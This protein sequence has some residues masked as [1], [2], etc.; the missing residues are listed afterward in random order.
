M[1]GETEEK[2]SGWTVDT[3]RVDFLARLDASDKRYEQ[4]FIAAEKAVEAAL[5]A[6][7]TAMNKADLANEKRFEGTNEWRSAFGDLIATMMSRVESLALHEAAKQR[8]TGQ[9][10]RLDS[11]EDRLRDDIQRKRGLADGWAYLIAAIGLVA[12]VVAVVLALST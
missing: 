9:D 4:R 7:E 10:A 3:A 5:A 1:A 11:L 2:P 8:D 6:A 12:T